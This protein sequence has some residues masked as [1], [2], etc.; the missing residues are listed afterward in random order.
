MID[1]TEI[2]IGYCEFVHNVKRFLNVG[3]VIFSMA[4]CGPGSSRFDVLRS[5][6]P[7]SATPDLTQR[8]NKQFRI[9]ER[10]RRSQMLETAY[11]RRSWYDHLDESLALQYKSST[12]TS[13]SLR[14]FEV[15]RWKRQLASS[16]CT[17]PSYMDR[18]CSLKTDFFKN[19]GGSRS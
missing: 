14:T 17:L 18:M 19:R 4:W 6:A 1:E 12:G 9:D 15:R 2:D 11:A 8:P 5:S 13:S 10:T 3:T 16:V 7:C